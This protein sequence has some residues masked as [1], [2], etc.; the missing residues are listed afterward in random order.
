MNVQGFE[1]GYTAKRLKTKTGYVQLPIT[2]PAIGN[3]LVVQSNPGP[4]IWNGSWQSAGTS[5]GGISDSTKALE[6]NVS[7]QPVGIANNPPTAGQILTATSATNAIWQVPAVPPIATLATTAQKLAT[8][9]G[10]GNDVIV[11]S[12]NCAGSG[13]VLVSTSATDAKWSSKVPSA[14][15]ADVSTVTNALATTSTNVVVSGS[16]APT[17]GK[18]LVADSGTQATWQT[19]VPQADA[20]SSASGKVSTLAAPAPTVGQYLVASSGT[21]ATWASPP[22]T[23]AQSNSTR[24]LATTSTDVYVDASAAPSAGK[25]LVAD[26]NVQATWQSSVPLSTNSST[27]NALATTGTAVNVSLAGPPSTG[28]VLQATSATTATWQALGSG[29]QLFAQLVSNGTTSM[30][31][32]AANTYYRFP[33]T[34]SRVSQNLTATPS[35]PATGT[36][37][38]S[39][40]AITIIQAGYYTFTCDL[41][42]NQGGN[43]T[44]QIQAFVNGSPTGNPTTFSTNTPSADSFSS[45]FQSITNTSLASGTV[46]DVRMQCTTGTPTISISRFSVCGIALASGLQGP[47][48]PAGPAGG[49][50]FYE[51]TNLGNYASATIN[52]INEQRFSSFLAPSTATITKIDFF[53]LQNSASKSYQVALYTGDGTTKLNEVAFTVP[54]ITATGVNEGSIVTATFPATVLTTDTKYFLGVGPTAN[55]GGTRQWFGNATGATNAQTFNQLNSPGV[56]TLPATATFSANGGR[57][58][59]RLRP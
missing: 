18:V 14:A 38:T 20:L 22:T 54:Q 32:A 46:V 37:V 29:S 25:V 24:A 23:I 43:N 12:S 4:G 13:L 16:A 55:D 19:A 35:V 40:S 45:S 51:S 15:S 21:T 28:Q 9:A 59:F 48:G 47:T 36:P 56:G 34:V 3:V 1:P 57:L 39:G 26:S 52:M 10:P 8:L 6:T 53:V 5:G 44:F 2:D 58:Y 50:A 27:T 42:F 41:S 31:F 17:A 49:A 30:P 11:N 7:G 33:N